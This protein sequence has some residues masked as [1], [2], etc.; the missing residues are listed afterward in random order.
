M[1]IANA[2]SCALLECVRVGSH[3]VA[4]D[5]WDTIKVLDK[6]GK[7]AMKR[8]CGCAHAKHRET[9][10]VNNAYGLLTE[11]KSFELPQNISFIVLS[12]TV[13]RLGQKSRDPCYAYTSLS[14]SK[15]YMQW[16]AVAYTVSG[17]DEEEEKEKEKDRNSLM[18]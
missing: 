1:W 2:L 15:S 13:I 9:P 18:W 11:E 4:F 17:C 14:F 8:D 6:K 7:V 3:P 16:K 10:A 12:F 5:L